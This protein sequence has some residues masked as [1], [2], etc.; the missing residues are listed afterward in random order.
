MSQGVMNQLNQ[1]QQQAREYWHGISSRERQ[2]I[3]IAAP[4]LLVWIIWMGIVQ[5]VL[6]K[7]EQAQQDLVNNQQM[8]N[9]VK[10]TASEILR[11]QA[12]GA[13]ITERPDIPLDQ[14]INRTASDHGLRVTGVRTQ[15]NR[16][17]VSLANASFD[18]LMS[19]LV[20][21]EQGSSVVIQ[22]L[23]VEQTR[24][25]GIVSIERLELSEG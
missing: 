2:L 18:Q 14:L 5:P 4:L 1:L 7:H 24:E 11:L 25:P 15:Q 3:V 20:E 9:R 21:L 8:L 10:S 22:Q 23:R 19:W 16:L 13:V 17:Q 12:Q 6:D